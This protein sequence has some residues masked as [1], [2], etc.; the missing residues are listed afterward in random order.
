MNKRNWLRLSTS[1]VA[2]AALGIGA[3]RLMPSGPSTITVPSTISTPSSE[4]G[5][6]VSETTAVPTAKPSGSAGAGVLQRTADLSG[7]DPELKATALYREDATKRW[8]DLNILEGPEEG[9]GMVLDVVLQGKVI[10]SITLD[11]DATGKFQFRSNE[12][13]DIPS[14]TDGLKLQV[15]RPS[16][17]VVAAGTFSGAVTNGDDALDDD[18]ELGGASADDD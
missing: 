8:L 9:A 3:L 1:G 14:V 17:T 12:G 13:D 11:D 16:G 7:S 2:L 5:K 10:G 18:D 4:S 15:L 6:A